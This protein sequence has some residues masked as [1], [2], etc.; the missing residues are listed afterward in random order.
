[1]MR[2]WFIRFLGLL[3]LVVLVPIGPVAAIPTASMPDLAPLIRG[4]RPVVVNISTSQTIRKKGGSQ[5]HSLEE[6]PFNGSP[7]EDFFKKFFD[8]LP[9]QELRSRSLGSG[10]IIDESGYIITNNHVVEDA[11]EI[12]VRLDDDREF[13]A[14]IVGRDAKTDV[15]LIRIKSDTPLPAARLGNSDLAEIGSWVIAIGNPFG[16]EAT[17]TVGIISAKGRVIGTG[18][19]DNFIQTD[20]AINPGN[21]GGPLFNMNGEVVGINTA[22]FS[23][24]GGN[25]G[26]GFAIPVN[27]ANNVVDQLKKHGHVTRGWLGVRIQTIDQNLSEAFGLDKRTGALIASVEPGSP[28]DKAGLKQGDIIVT[29]DGK[30]IQKMTDLPAIVAAT[31]V[32][33]QSDIEVIRDNRRKTMHVVIAQMEEDKE[34]SGMAASHDKG[35]S[36]LGLSM[37]ALT[38]ELRQE[39][40][41]PAEVQ[42][43]VV[44]AV[45]SGSPAHESGIRQGDVISEINRRAVRSLADFKQAVHEVKQGQTILLLTIRQGEPRFVAIQIRSSK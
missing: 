20:A 7:F 15:A 24:S 26:I 29:F 41:I 17:V 5:G 32:G 25:M 11:S 4:L 43:L 45:T 35:E 9:E 38:Q 21:S 23:R 19:Y 16:L 33:K 10:V 31:P 27:M 1:M 8:Q 12:L 39:L 18:P 2:Q 22:I 13:K 44:A 14:T 36:I 28:A 6:N 3:C 30:P 37:R 42:G 40:R 34:S